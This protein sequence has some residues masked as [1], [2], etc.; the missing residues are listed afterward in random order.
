LSS[1]DDGKTRNK[2]PTKTNG[3]AGTTSFLQ[4]PKQAGMKPEDA[5]KACGEILEL[6]SN[7]LKKEDSDKLLQKVPDASK[8]LEDHEDTKTKAMGS[9]TG[10]G[11]AITGRSSDL[12]GMASSFL[13]GGGGGKAD[14]NSTLLLVL[15]MALHPCQ[16]SSKLLVSHLLWPF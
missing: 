16:H 8:L 9:K 11:G 3:T 14:T 5:K 12:M 15:V 6:L 2:K 1:K 13:G 10:A 7:N 4:V